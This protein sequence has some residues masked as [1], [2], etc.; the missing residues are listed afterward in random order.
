M[1]P[2]PLAGEG[3][4]GGVSAGDTPDVERAL[5]RRALRVD[6]SRKRERLSEPAAQLI[7]LKAHRA[8]EI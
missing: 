5:T 2:L 4:G 7:L 6:L 3:W 1:L 8:L